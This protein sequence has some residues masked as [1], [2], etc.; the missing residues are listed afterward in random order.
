MI[1]LQ[2]S[3]NTANIGSIV[4]IDDLKN[5]RGTFSNLGEDW[6]DDYWINYGNI[7]FI[8][9]DKTIKITR[10]KDY[11]E[12]KNREDLIEKIVKSAII[13]KK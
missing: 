1:S 5:E 2:G 11:L 4:N 9:D 13:K 3:G 12:F 8:K 7:T 6:F 10:L